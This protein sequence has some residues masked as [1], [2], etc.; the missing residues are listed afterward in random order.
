MEERKR[1]GFEVMLFLILLSGLFYLSYRRIWK[2][3]H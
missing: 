1:V 2:D 3:I